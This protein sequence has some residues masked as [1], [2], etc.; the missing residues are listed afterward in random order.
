MAGEVTETPEMR[1]VVAEI[2]RRAQALEKSLNALIAE[3]EKDTDCTV[4]VEQ[5]ELMDQRKVIVK[6]AI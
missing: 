5:V 1:A 3:L 2:R 6:A 4:F